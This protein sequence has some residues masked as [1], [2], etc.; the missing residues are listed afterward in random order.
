MVCW[1][2]TVSVTGT[3]T[4]MDVS[5]FPFASM[6]ATLVTASVIVVVTLYDTVS[7]AAPPTYCAGVTALLMVPI[8]MPPFICT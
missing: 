8:S 7:V 1:R 6:S 4:L 3:Y 5:A 2:L